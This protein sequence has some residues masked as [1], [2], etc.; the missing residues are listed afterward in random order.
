[1][2]RQVLNDIHESFVMCCSASKH[3]VLLCVAVLAS[4]S[5]LQN[6]EMCS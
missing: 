6:V 5:V 3:L 2:A 1:M 4:I